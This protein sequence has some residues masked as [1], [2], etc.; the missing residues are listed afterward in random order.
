MSY[1]FIYSTETDLS[2]DNGPG[3][4]EREFVDALIK[5]YGKQVRCVIP[6]P[7]YP[8]IYFNENIEYVFP[9]T[10]NPLR[11]MVYL[12]A[13]FVRIVK[14]HMDFPCD[15]LVFRLG[16]APIVPLLLSYLL[17]KPLFLKTLAGYYAFE[18][19]NRDMVRKL[20]ARITEP[21]YRA[22]IQRSFTADTVSVSY[23]EWLN[24]KFGI[25]KDRLHYIPNG[26]NTDFFCPRDKLKSKKDLG[27]DCF[28]WVVGYVGALDSLRHIDDLIRAL[29]LLQPIDQ[30][31]LV[32]VGSGEGE[33]SFK[34]L[35]RSMG[36]ESRIVFT[37]KVP[38]QDVPSYMNAFNV[39][40]DLSLIPMNMHGAI[41]NGS[42][43]QKIPQYL[44]CGIPVIAWNTPDTLFLKQERIGDLAQVGDIQSLAGAIEGQ[45]T[46]CKLEEDDIQHRARTYAE[47]HFSIR[48]L[49]SR[50]IALW[51][52][53]L[54]A[55]VGI[56]E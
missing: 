42:Y 37:G 31:G 50:R 32:L 15:A 25:D 55:I 3:I 26:V 6:Y 21:L 22:V 20:S 10:S 35:A 44:S 11:Y 47:S 2:I 48:I 51:E 27:L 8:E 45:L 4:N 9:Y 14:L 33:M 43:S 13:L 46:R 16:I 17:K 1:A 40:V 30:V 41:Y 24:Y 52:A 54:N 29:P 12:G 53:S 19:E 49:A 34:E 39:A 5:T 28:P 7:K 56:T 36:V 23:I 38:Y 18:K